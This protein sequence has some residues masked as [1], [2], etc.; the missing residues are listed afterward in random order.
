MEGKLQP[1][2]PS[3]FTIKRLAHYSVPSAKASTSPAI[4][5]RAIDPSQ[6]SHMQFK[7]QQ[8]YSF[9]TTY[10]ARCVFAFMYVQQ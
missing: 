10:L 8:I 2:P 1:P 6:Y 3:F 9:S 7:S 4:P 5:H